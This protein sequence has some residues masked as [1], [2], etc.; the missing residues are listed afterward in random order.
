M[1]QR[2]TRRTHL[3]QAM[4]LAA[5]AL[6]TERLRA[7]EANRFPSKKDTFRLP[8]QGKKIP[9]IFDTDIGDDIDDTWALLMLLKSPELD[10][11]L[12]ASDGGNAMYRARL[13]GK[14]LEAYGRSDVPIAVGLDPADRRSRQSPWLGDYDL[15]L[16]PGKVHRDGVAALID[17]I[18]K[19]AEPVTL[20]CTG[21]V[22]NIA[23]ALRRDS[24]ICQHARFV[25]MH[26]SVRRGYNGQ[27]KTSPEYNV[28]A[29]PKALQSVFA[30]PWDVSITPLD[31]CG[32]VQLKGE[33]F[34]K[35]Y[36]SRARGVA[37]LME[38]YRVWATDG[39]RS[40]KGP[41]P[42][43]I[44]SILFDT[45]AAY[46]AFSEDLLE[47]ESLPLRVTD[48]G[49]TIVEQGARTVHCA[50]NWKDLGAYED[51]LVSRVTA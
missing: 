13:L 33:K 6:G 23:E 3:K 36:D 11:R 32:I 40:K 35:V 21:P 10:V 22:P 43:K 15:T 51:L 14:L 27:T 2:I 42:T 12:V 29:N 19:S 45:V 16:Y 25:G 18:Q 8:P 5:G 38:N 39:G 48:E 30:A 7:A 41:D 1:N 26:G 50:L 34:R 47:M 46:M 24:S 37:A 4:A 31:T 44:S 20:V 17:T 28:R 9:V 49:M